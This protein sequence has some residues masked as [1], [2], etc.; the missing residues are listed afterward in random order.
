MRTAT[1][2]LMPLVLL[3]AC[4]GSSDGG[5]SDGGS[6]DGGADAGSTFTLHIT[7]DLKWCNITVD[8]TTTTAASPADK[9][10]AAGTVVHLSAVPTSGTFIWGYW[11]GTDGA[12]ATAPNHD[13]NATTTVTMSANKSVTACCPFTNG[14]GC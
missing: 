4:G 11:T 7:N 3:A 12:S 5:S 1:A 10:Y 6:S 13:T 8:G 2:L 14:T 9:S